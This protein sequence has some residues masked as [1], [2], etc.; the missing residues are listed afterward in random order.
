M[1]K[2]QFL[3]E[4]SPSHYYGLD[5][6]VIDE[7]LVWS[8]AHPLPLI[9]DRVRIKMNNIGYGTVVAYFTAKGNVRDGVCVWYVGVEVDLEPDTVAAW[10]VRQNGVD[11]N[12]LVFGTEIEPAPPLRADVIKACQ[13]DSMDVADMMI[14]PYLGSDESEGHPERVSW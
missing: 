5:A 8:G 1:N 11:R 9:G 14:E 7:E 12:S 4:N 10:Y 3:A 13:D 6:V 2:S